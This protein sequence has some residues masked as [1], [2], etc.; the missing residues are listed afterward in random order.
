[1]L[2]T[3]SILRTLIDAWPVLK[4]RLAQ[5]TDEERVAFANHFNEEFEDDKLGDLL[6]GD[7]KKELEYKIM[8][9]DSDVADDFA[10][11]LLVQEVIDR[12]ELESSLDTDS[13]TTE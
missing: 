5:I 9:L 6:M 2:D 11:E 3:Q 7:S 8:I 10:E 12:E 13:T 4:E 1:M